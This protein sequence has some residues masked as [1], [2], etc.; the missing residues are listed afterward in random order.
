MEN[1]REILFSKFGITLSYCK[2]LD[3]YFLGHWWVRPKFP[4]F[5]ITSYNATYLL[6]EYF[7]SISGTMRIIMRGSLFLSIICYVL[8]L[9]EGPGYLPYYYPDEYKKLPNGEPDYVSGLSLTFDQRKKMSSIANGLPSFIDY[10]SCVK[11]F[12]I[13]PDHFCR[14]A[15]TFIGVKNHKLF[16]LFCFYSL[17]FFIAFSSV[18]YRVVIENSFVNTI[19]IFLFLISFIVILYIGSI[20]IESIID[21]FMGRTRLYRVKRIDA[22]NEGSF[23][24]FSASAK[25]VFGK[26]YPLTWFIPYSPYHWMSDYDIVTFL[27]KNDV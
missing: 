12:V 18:V 24:N 25:I 27:K 6:A 1:E 3:A 15:G 2:E 23:E 20:L 19:R 11:S 26:N 4:I 22:K 7:F 14:W 10:F 5:V 17:I 9:Y 13:R 21:L 8:L 16:V